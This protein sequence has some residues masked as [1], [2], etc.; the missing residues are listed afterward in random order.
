MET[1]RAGHFP[2]SIRSISAG[3]LQD[4]ILQ[5]NC[6]AYAFQL[7]RLKGFFDLTEGR[8][9]DFDDT[10]VNAMVAELDPKPRHDAVNCDIVIYSTDTRIVHAGMVSGQGVR[11]KWGTGYI[12]D[13]GTFEIPAEHGR[14]VRYFASQP[15]EVI[16]ER[17][18]LH[19]GRQIDA[20]A[21]RVEPGDSRGTLI[22]FDT[23]SVGLVRK[24]QRPRSRISDHEPL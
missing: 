17:F 8:A 21:A 14:S 22:A 1:L 18:L 16:C 24:P 9:V 13:H 4:R 3:S 11:S 12:W 2:H 20:A 7:W 10:L 19:A 23:S 6:F 15:P 5:F